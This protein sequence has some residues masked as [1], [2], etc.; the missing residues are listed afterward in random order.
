MDT[1]RREIYMAA[2]AELKRAPTSICFALCKSIP[3]VPLC[4]LDY[5]AEISPVLPD[6]YSMAPKR[7]WDSLGRSY[8]VASSHDYWWDLD[9][10]EARIRFLEQLLSDTHGTF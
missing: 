9:M 4:V 8:M 10:R 6:W 5:D 3:G 1:F 7:F 2:L